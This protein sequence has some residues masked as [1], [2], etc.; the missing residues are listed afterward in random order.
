MRGHT[1]P[2]GSPGLGI[3]KLLRCYPSELPVDEVRAHFALAHVVAA[4]TH[5]LQQQLPQHHISGRAKACPAYG[6]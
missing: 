2:P 6:C 5:E 3:G 1:D 4:V